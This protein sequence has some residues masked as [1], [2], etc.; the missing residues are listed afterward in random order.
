MNQSDISGN[1]LAERAEQ[2][3]RGALDWSLAG[4]WRPWIL[5]FLFSLLMFLPGQMSI[6]PVDRDEARFVQASKQMIE[7]GD[8]VDI[9]FQD[10][11]RHK[12]PV[13]IY[14]LQTAAANWSG[15]SAEAPIWIYRLPSMLGATLAVLLTFW[16]GQVLVSRQATFLGA[17]MLAASLIPGVEAH[18]AKTDAVLFAA[19]IAALG[20]LARAYLLEPNKHFGPPIMVL[21]WVA[22]GIGILIKGPI[23]LLVTG[24]T[25]TALCIVDRK[26][27]WLSSLRPL[28]GIPLLLLIILPWFVAIYQKT[29]GQ[30]F[31]ASIGHDMLGKAVSGQESHG[32]PPGTYLLLL[33]LI[34]WPFAPY[35]ILAVPNIWRYRAQAQIKFLLAWAIPTW[36][37]FEIFPT[38]LPHYVLPVFP[39]LALL[40]AQVTLES[41]SEVISRWRYL[42]AWWLLLLCVGLPLG[43][44][45]ASI[46]LN[47]YVDFVALAGLGM[48]AIAGYVGFHILKNGKPFGSMLAVFVCAALTLVTTFGRVFPKLDP[49]WVS[50]RMVEEATTHA[51]CQK[52]ELASVGYSEPSLVFLGGTRTRLTDERGALEFLASGQCRMVFV[53]KRFLENFRDMLEDRGQDAENVGHVSGLNIAKGRFVSLFLFR[54][55]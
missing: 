16:A 53:E 45:A 2:S 38:K 11:P 31:L 46:W 35:L 10:A 7:S 24:L 17:A 33:G 5:L 18:L 52:P 26:I 54:M 34:Y 28:W 30:F 19:I 37:I 25:I 29:D 14:W 50:S 20:C 42:V 3:A 22:M 15:Y 13:G 21:F 47:G 32:A 8:Y 49:V 36:I 9:R 4:K 44:A 51:S 6:P 1:T 55:D 12:K 23:I 48:A 40:T 39:A 43:L 41:I 27:G